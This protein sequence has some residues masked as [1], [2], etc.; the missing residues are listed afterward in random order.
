MSAGMVAPV[1]NRRSEDVDSIHTVEG[2]PLSPP[3]PLTGSASMPALGDAYAAQGQLQAHLAATLSA[4]A[5][6][7]GK[8]ALSASVLTQGSGYHAIR[9]LHHLHG[10]DGASSL[11][12]KKGRGK[13]GLKDGRS[14]AAG[15]PGARISLALPQTNKHVEKLAREVESLAQQLD[16]TLRENEL[17]RLEISRLRKQV[18]SVS[19]NASH[20]SVG[21]KHE[22]PGL[23]GSLSEGGSL[24]GG[25]VM[26]GSVENNA[27]NS[28]TQNRSAVFM[29]G[30]ELEEDSNLLHADLYGYP[31][32]DDKAVMRVSGQRSVPSSNS[33]PRH[34]AV[35]YTNAPSSKQ[36]RILV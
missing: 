36:V 29:E 28:L 35:G 32:E 7:S 13:E 18:M 31:S 4:L 14:G 22:A 6:S 9:S 16:D 33:A 1:H 11:H 19:A 2:K 5:S 15:E 10:A 17:Y 8:N 20:A 27:G 24:L 12:G 23:G 34:S 26:A 21:S 3:R 25:G 30:L